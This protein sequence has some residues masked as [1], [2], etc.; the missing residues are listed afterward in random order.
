[1]ELPMK[2]IVK[3]IDLITPM[4]IYEEDGKYTAVCGKSHPDHIKLEDGGVLTFSSSAKAIEAERPA[5]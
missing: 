2:R 1:M 5:Q 3:T 4:T